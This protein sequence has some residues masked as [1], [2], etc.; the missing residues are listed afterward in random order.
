MPHRH[1]F[2]DF[3]YPFLGLLL[4][5]TLFFL[6]ENFIV[7]LTMWI[8]FFDMIFWNDLLISFN[9]IFWQAL[10]WSS[11]TIFWCDLLTWSSDMIF[12][13]YL[14]IWYFYMI[15]WN[16][17]WYDLLMWSFDCLRF[18]IVLWWDWY[19]SCSQHCSF[20]IRV[21]CYE[22]FKFRFIEV[23][24]FIICVLVIFGIIIILMI[25]WWL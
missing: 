11:D 2:F 19:V 10:I 4:F 21:K 8:D 12:W 25:I 16:V 20:V 24:L 5:D 22:P 3:R 23:F 17:F 14:L 1:C 15:F 6:L 13:Y 7:T 18:I 9:M